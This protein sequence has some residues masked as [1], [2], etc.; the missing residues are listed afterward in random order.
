MLWG[1]QGVG[2]CGG[3]CLLSIQDQNS[4][5]KVELEGAGEWWALTALPPLYEYLDAAFFPTSGV[6]VHVCVWGKLGACE[7][8]NVYLAVCS[9]ISRPSCLHKTQVSRPKGTQPVRES[10]GR[11]HGDWMV[12]KDKLG[13]LYLIS[14]YTIVNAPFSMTCDCDYTPQAKCQHP[15]L[16]I[17]PPQRG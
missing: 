3:A 13:M 5:R 6:C 8:W 1:T 2:W 9:Q 12:A 4:S 11:Q 14:S 15:H 10:T 16:P 17:H 7:R